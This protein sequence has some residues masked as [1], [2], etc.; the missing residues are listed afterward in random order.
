MNGTSDGRGGVAELVEHIQEQSAELP[1]RARQAA[2]GWGA[3]VQRFVRRNPVGALLGA[4][5]IG[6]ALARAARHV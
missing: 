5:V 6:V 2:Q 4:F 1:A 3:E